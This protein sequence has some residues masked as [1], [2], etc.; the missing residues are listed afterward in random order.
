[1]RV[2]VVAG[3]DAGHAFPAIALSLRLCAVGDYPVLFTGAAW[4]ERAASAGIET[5]LL[6]GL[7]ADADD[8]DIDAGRRLH[9][10]AARMAVLLREDLS[11]TAEPGEQGTARVRSAA[12]GLLAE[13]FDLV[14]SDV[15][16][17]AGGLAA[18]LCGIPWVEL[19]PHPLYR[20]SR[21]LPPIGSGLD[22]GRGPRGRARDVVL[23]AMTGRAVK[24]GLRQRSEAREGIGLPARDPGPAARLIATLPDLE[25]SRVDWPVEARLV[26]P[27]HWEPTDRIISPPA[28]PHPLVVVAPSTA[29]TGAPG[30][31]EASIAALSQLPV[32]VVVSTLHRP[33][34]LPAEMTAGAGRQD[35]LLEQADAV[36]CGAGHGL[37]SKALARGVPVIAVPGGGDQWELAK[38]AERL[39]CAV[40]VRPVTADAVRDA[41]RTVLENPSYRRA[42]QRVAGN[43]HRVQDPVGVCHAVI[44][45]AETF[46][47]PVRSWASVGT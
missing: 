7:E 12:G 4:Q 26:G 31:L 17:A 14:V 9:Q 18:E 28:G 35:V 16:T 13:P 21:S 39:G 29:A 24:T 47:A 32:R 8:P 6:R 5:R 43:A 30:M 34:G 42:A 38:R 23:R 22:R 11:P 15:L 2:A 3:P 45:A 44:G 27:L 37:L 1:M 40:T 25:A 41:V 36:I 20:P 19:S 33:P 10:R 46:R